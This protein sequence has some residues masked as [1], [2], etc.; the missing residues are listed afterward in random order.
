[1]ALTRRLTVEGRNEFAA[2]TRRGGKQADLKM[3]AER[4]IDWPG[5][6]LEF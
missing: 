5:L 4:P 1:M 6:I 3:L 2:E